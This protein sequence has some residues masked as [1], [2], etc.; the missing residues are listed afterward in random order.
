MKPYFYTFLAL[1]VLAASPVCAADIG[2]TNDTI[3]PTPHNA[4][5]T[6]IPYHDNLLG[7]LGGARDILSEKGVEVLLEYKADSFAV[8]QGGIKRGGAYL[9]NL[10]LRFDMDNEKLFGW[11]GNKSAIHFTNN[12]GGRPGARLVG[13]AMGI[14]NIETTKSAAI[15]YEAWDD[16][17]FLHDTLSIRAGMSDVNNEFMITES[18]LNFIQPT[19]QLGQTFAQSG[20]NGPPTFP[21]TSLGARVKYLPTEETYT[22][23]AIFNAV[24]GD[25]DHLYGNT[26]FQFNG[27][28]LLIAEGGFTP[29][30]QGVDSKPDILALG[31]WMY[32]QKTAELVTLDA[33]GSPVRH[34]SFGGYALSSYLFYHDKD[35]RGLNAFFRPSFADGDTRRVAYAYEIGMVGT[36]WVPGRPDSEIGVG[37]SQAINGD[38]FREAAIAAGSE[39]EKS[40]YALDVYYR[41]KIIPGF[42]LQP[43]IQYI[44]NP[45]SAPGVKDA[46]VVG[47]RCDLN[48]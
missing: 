42:T 3:Q 7:S 22:Q 5:P 23:A 25:P 32:T 4:E 20:V 26:H 43:D 30:V 17:S 11:K 38:K 46:V 45:G 6:E 47:L 15:L 18:S 8:T 16:Q 44:K 19:M 35:E 36:K 1:G 10:D 29:K 14:D 41:D 12:F 48:F 31:G 2:D 27:G 37:L 13:N 9:D 33:N 21:Y 24:A 28:A 40:E 39:A 34:R